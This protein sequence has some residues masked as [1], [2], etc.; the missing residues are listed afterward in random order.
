[1]H[2]SLP[3]LVAGIILKYFVYQGEHFIFVVLSLEEQ[4]RCLRFG[5]MHHVASN[6]EFMSIT[7]CETFHHWLRWNF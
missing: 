1:V 3:E 5:P 6:A 2:R 7:I 4:Y